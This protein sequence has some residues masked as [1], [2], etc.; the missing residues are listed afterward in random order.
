MYELISF[1]KFVWAIN[2]VVFYWCFTTINFNVS[3]FPAVNI[4]SPARS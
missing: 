4:F 3:H 2:F 1:R